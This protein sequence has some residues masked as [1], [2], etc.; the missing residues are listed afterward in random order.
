[1]FKQG[2]LEQR[3]LMVFFFCFL[4]VVSTDNFF[5]FV[6]FCEF[7]S[8][9][10]RLSLL[11]RLSKG[12]VISRLLSTIK[13]K[14]KLELCRFWN[15]CKSFFNSSVS[16]EPLFILFEIIIFPTWFLA[17]A[18]PSWQRN[19]GRWISLHTRLLDSI[20]EKKKK[21]INIFREYA[22]VDVHSL[23]AKKK[24]KI[25]INRRILGRETR[26]ISNGFLSP[27]W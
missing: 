3:H 8:N 2:P 19:Q 27:S 16:T 21:S 17:F 25:K 5:C 13:N 7:Y 24:Q 12:L 1:M 18:E 15:P 11:I 4:S 6:F 22:T 14:R 10:E 9:N 20:F 26:N 23:R